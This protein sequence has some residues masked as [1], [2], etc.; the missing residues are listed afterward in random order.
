MEFNKKSILQSTMNINDKVKIALK[1]FLI[2]SIIEICESY[3]F[4]IVCAMCETYHPRGFCAK[5]CFSKNRMEVI[6]YQFNSVLKGCLMNKE[7]RKTIPLI[8]VDDNDNEFWDFV[9]FS[10]QK[11]YPH[12][13]YKIGWHNVEDCQNHDNTS[14]LKMRVKPMWTNGKYQHPKRTPPIIQFSFDNSDS[15]WHMWL[16]PV[17]ISNKKPKIL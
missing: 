4:L 2:N 10:I 9:S 1:P 5:E 8:F 11:E 14:Q 12:H 17:K 13:K 7:K 3:H 6:F 16:E 15:N